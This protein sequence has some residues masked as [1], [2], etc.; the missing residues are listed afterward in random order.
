MA[1]VFLHYPTDK[2][3]LTAIYPAL[4][5]TGNLRAEKGSCHLYRADVYAHGR[6]IKFI[7]VPPAS[8]NTSFDFDDVFKL[9]VT[10]YREAL[11]SEVYLGAARLY[12][13]D[14]TKQLYRL[15][16]LAG[17]MDVPMIATNDVHYHEPARR[18]LQDILTCVREKCTIHNAGFRLHANAERYLKP[19]AEMQRLFRQYPEAITHTQEIS[20]ALPVLTGQSQI[21][22]S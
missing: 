12:N 8:L 10:E 2:E 6:G 9:A 20:E 13:G 5:T 15:S 17:Q 18:E 22:L 21:C 16:R 4:L 7:V 14:D 19:A 11:G 3:T 1:P